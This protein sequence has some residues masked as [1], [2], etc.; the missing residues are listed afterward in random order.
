[1]KIEPILLSK[2]TPEEIARISEDEFDPRRHESFYGYIPNYPPPH[3]MYNL[4]PF[5]LIE[6]D[7][8]K[9]QESK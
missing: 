8:N 4:N 6:G 3:P 9:S 2:M 7:K 5:D 1:M